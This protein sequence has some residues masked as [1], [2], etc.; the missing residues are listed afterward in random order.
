MQEVLTLLIVVA[1][2]VFCLF[3]I[4]RSSRGDCQNCPNA[5]CKKRK[6]ITSDI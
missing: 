3:K 4:K 1:A 6:K 5:C 2:L